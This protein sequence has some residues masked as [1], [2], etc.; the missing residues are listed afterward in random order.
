MEMTD[1][2]EANENGMSLVGE[3]HSSSH[4]RFEKLIQKESNEIGVSQQ[5]AGCKIM[6]VNFHNQATFNT[7]TKEG[8]ARTQKLSSSLHIFPNASTIECD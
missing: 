1:S 8:S 4:P 6:L 5:T 2:D 3:T 7:H